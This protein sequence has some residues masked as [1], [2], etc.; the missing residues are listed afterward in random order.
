MYHVSQHMEDL[1]EKYYGD[2][3]LRKCLGLIQGWGEKPHRGYAAS[4]LIKTTAD[5]LFICAISNF[6]EM[7]K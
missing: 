6:T 5:L 4:I 3:I 7:Q 2:L 1:K